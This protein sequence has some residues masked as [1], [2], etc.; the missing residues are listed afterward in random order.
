MDYIH[1]NPVRAKVGFAEQVTSYRWSSLPRFIR[2]PKHDGLTASEWLRAR[3]G[4]EDD[5]LGWKAYEA[6]LIDLGKDEGRWEQERLVGLSCRK[7]GPSVLLV[8]VEP[9]PRSTLNLR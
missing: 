5:A 8:G 1:L 6:H 4:W 3:G 7:A 9:S 2:G